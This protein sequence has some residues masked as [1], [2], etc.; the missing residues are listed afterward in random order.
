MNDDCVCLA[1]VATMLVTAYFTRR[2]CADAV[3]HGRRN[4]WKKLI[5][6]A[7]QRCEYREF[8]KGLDASA[9]LARM[10]GEEER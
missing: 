4:W 9:E 5:C 3:M 6:L 1:L 2:F 8:C 10:I 7:Q